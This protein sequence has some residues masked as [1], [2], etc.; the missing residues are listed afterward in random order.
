MNTGPQTDTAPTEQTV[1]SPLSPAAS[2]HLTH[3]ARSWVQRWAAG[4]GTLSAVSL[5]ALLGPLAL[6]AAI[7]GFWTW[8]GTPGSLGIALNMLHWA[9]PSGQKLHSADVQGNLQQGGRIGQISWQSE[10][11]QMQAQEAQLV[12]DWSQLWRQAWPVQSIALQS[13]R[14]QDQRSP[15]PMKPLTELRLPLPLQL[16]LK[17]DQFSWQGS[18]AVKLSDVQG[19]YAFD[20]QEHRLDIDSLALAQGR[21]TLQARLQGAA[22]MALSISAQGQVQT[23]A[24][25]RTPALQLQVQ[26]KVQGQLS[27]PQAQLSVQTELAPTPG[28]GALGRAQDKVHLSLQAQIQPWQEQVVLQAE[29][30]WQALDLAPLWPG[31]PQT[32]LQGQ[33][34]LLP[35]GAAWQL[36][37]Q[38]EN[39]LPGAWDL[40]RLPLAQLSLKARH[41][42]GLWQ[43]KQ[44]QARMAAGQVQGQGQQTPQGWTGQVDIQNLQPASLHSAWNGPAMQGRLKAEATGSD[45]I[46]LSADLQSQ[47]ATGRSPSI[48]V[49]LQW[50]KLQLTGQWHPDRWDIDRLHMQAARAELEAQFRWKPTESEVQGRITLQLPGLQATAQGNLA[51]INGQGRLD[52]QMQDA[53]LSQAW[54][55]GL[56][57]W[58]AQLKAFKASGPAQLQAQWQGGYAQAD[59]PLSLSLQWPRIDWAQQ[60]SVSTATNR[61][62]PAPATWFLMPGQLQIRGTPLALKSEIQASFGQG[63]HTARV[64]TTLNASRADTLSPNWQ[65]LIEQLTISTPNTQNPSAAPWRLDLQPSLALQARQEQA[66]L[67]WGPSNWQLQGPGPGTARLQAEAGA[68]TAPRQGQAMQ[69]HGAV[70]WTDLPVAW[71][72]AWLGTD[73]L[74]DIT[75]QGQ[76][77]WRLDQDLHLSLSAERSQGDLRVQT[78]SLTRQRTA[79]GLRQAKVL[80]S[81][82]NEQLHAEIKWDSAQMGQAQANFKSQLNRTPDGWQWSDTAPLIGSLQAKL[83]QIGAWSVLAPP[84]WRVQGTLDADLTMSGTRSQPQWQ[85]RLLAKQLAA[86]S[87]VQGIEFS[88]GQMLARLEGQSLILEN[89]SLRGAGAQGGELQAR[90]EVQFNATPSVQAN[91]QTNPLASAHLALQIEAK[92]LRVSNRADRRLS[93]SGDLNA[94]MKQGQFQLRGGLKANQA[95]FILP[96]DSTPNLGDD[97]VVFRPGMGELNLSALKALPDPNTPSSSWLGVPDVRVLLELGNDFQIQGQGLSTRLNGQVELLSNASTQGLP[98]LS[99]QVR[100]EGGRYKAYGQ[101]LKIDTGVLR[102]TGPYDNPSL[103]IIALRPNL[104]QSVGVQ[105]TGTALLP[106]IRL[107]ADPDLPDADKLAWLVLGRSA[108]NGGAESVVLQQAAMSLLSG[109]GKTLSGDLANSL[110]LDE[111][112]LATGSRSD[113]TATG[114]AVT[115]GK[116]LSKDFYLAYETSLSGAFGSLYIFYDLSRRVTLRAQAGEQSALDLIFTMRRD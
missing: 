39:L 35:D 51:P 42:Q 96:D 37:A 16:K 112:S 52:L 102:F 78:D 40:Q 11:L 104:P 49:A 81:A 100:T 74:N 69:T 92:N 82:Q 99:G 2:N 1:V 26:S 101:Q 12:L 47:K 25:D 18:T 89:L 14:V 113:A 30:Q 60:G 84:G 5:S 15:Q 70:R 53:A 21:Y 109:N 77:Q 13:L 68:W 55:Q 27:G 23:P 114:A 57:G 7:W 24:S 95:L 59:A 9:L 54:L 75:L 83:P 116:R 31:A 105:I 41:D 88:Q 80:L 6:A 17:V 111:I 32:R 85:G 29:G 61:S 48:P 4:L 44:A 38:I 22:P 71:A 86:R 79:A 45:T 62:T 36:D 43:V 10:G 33:A 66:T 91:R 90:G 64:Q 3:R 72:Q 46:A 65:G 19:Q 93:V 50:E 87:A 8:T 73:I 20:G 63:R 76:A 67:T 103:N 115:L 94:L 110:G 58:G 107:Y 108:A 56:P 97:V 34:Q 98:R 106:R 28:Q